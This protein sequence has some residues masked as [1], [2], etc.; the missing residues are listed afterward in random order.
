[1]PYTRRIE[2][3]NDGEL[4]IGEADVDT[5]DYASGWRIKKVIVT[6][7]DLDIKVLWAG[8]YAGFT[9]RWDERSGLFYS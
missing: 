5:A 8:K 1:M 3:I 2:L 7:P 4:Y 6:S 9:Q